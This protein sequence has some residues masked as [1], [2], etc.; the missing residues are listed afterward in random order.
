LHRVY[1]PVG[2]IV[3]FDIIALII[4]FM[5]GVYRF[6]AVVDT[7]VAHL[8]PNDPNVYILHSNILISNNNS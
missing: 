6:G 5:P 4:A 1:A 2:S 8:L 3:A 7:V